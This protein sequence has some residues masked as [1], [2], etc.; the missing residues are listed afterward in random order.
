MPSR[1]EGEG[2]FHL[3]ARSTDPRWI[4]LRG[5]VLRVDSGCKRQGNGSPNSSEQTRIPVDSCSPQ[6]IQRYSPNKLPLLLIR[7]TPNL[8]LTHKI[9]ASSCHNWT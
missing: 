4:E 2:V 3:C 5:D 8:T 6:R 7:L 1:L 9:G